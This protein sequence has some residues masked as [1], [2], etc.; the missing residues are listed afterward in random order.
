[1][2][3]K[4]VLESDQTTKTW[5]KPPHTFNALPLAFCR[6]HLRRRRLLLLP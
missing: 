4:A 1:M 5:I 2:I 3:M 6:C